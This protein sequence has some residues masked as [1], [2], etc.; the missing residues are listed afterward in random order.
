VEAHIQARELFGDLCQTRLTGTYVEEHASRA[1]RSLRDFLLEHLAA[2]VGTGRE[3]EDAITLVALHRA[4][5]GSAGTSVTPA[6]S[7]HQLLH[8]V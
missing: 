8:V 4:A 2:C 3:Q 1:E 5:G 7:A 6:G